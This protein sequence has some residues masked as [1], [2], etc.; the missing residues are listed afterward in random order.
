MN[1]SPVDAATINQIASRLPIYRKARGPVLLL[2]VII[3]FAYQFLTLPQATVM[4]LAA[5]VPV[6]ARFPLLTKVALG[7]F[8]VGMFSDLTLNYL[9]HMQSSTSVRWVYMR[10]YFDQAGHVWAAV[11]AGALTAWMILDV[12]VLAGGLDPVVGFGVGA[13][14][15]VASQYALAFKALLPFYENTPYG[16]LENRAWDGAS[17]SFA[18]AVLLE[19]GFK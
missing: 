1:T 10:E 11:F 17:T 14:W 15:G 2:T 3:L 19:L 5:L 8:L 13:A 7:G 4:M 9:A 6:L 16:Y 18:S 12:V